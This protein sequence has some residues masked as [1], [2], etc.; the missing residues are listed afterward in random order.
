MTGAFLLAD[1]VHVNPP[2]LYVFDKGFGYGNAWSS[3]VA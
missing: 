3:A 1:A 2:S